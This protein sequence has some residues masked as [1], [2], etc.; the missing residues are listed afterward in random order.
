[1]NT[2]L[3]PATKN[4]STHFGEFTVPRIK[5]ETALTTTNDNQLATVPKDLDLYR[6]AIEAG[7]QTLVDER[8]KAAAARVIFKILSNECRDVV[9]KHSL[10]VQTSPPRVVQPTT[11]T[12]PA[13]LSAK[14]YQL[15]ELTD[16]PQ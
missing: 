7:R 9:C 6:Q 1:L 13:N 8:S 15:T 5:T 2:R 14:S 4:L 12:S 16:R 3:H 10:K 11:T